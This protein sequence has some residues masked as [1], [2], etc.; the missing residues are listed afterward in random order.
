M[1]DGTYCING[2]VDKNSYKC[3][4]KSI[5]PKCKSK[6]ESYTWDAFI[7]VPSHEHDICEGV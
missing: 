4:G 7:I 2:V 5:D 1:N 6:R 3:L